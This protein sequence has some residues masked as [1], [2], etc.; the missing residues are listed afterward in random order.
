MRKIIGNKKGMNVLLIEIGFLLFNL[1]IFFGIAYGVGSFADRDI[2]YEQAY[3]KRIALLIDEAKLNTSIEL[4][5][6]ELM[7]KAVKNKYGGRIVEIEN[8]KIIVRV[9]EKGGY[10]FGYF[11][12]VAVGSIEDRNKQ[13]LILDIKNAK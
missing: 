13:I 2:I 8:N 1:I 7:N 11:S 3:A 9:S 6:S 4:D 12:D 10:G 5:I